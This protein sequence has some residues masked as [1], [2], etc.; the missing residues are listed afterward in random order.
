MPKEAQ[1]RIRINR[2]FDECGFPPSAALVL[3]R[4]GKGKIPPQSSHMRRLNLAGIRLEA[5][6]IVLS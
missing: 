6:T 1:A 3:A 2:C 5:R 4:D